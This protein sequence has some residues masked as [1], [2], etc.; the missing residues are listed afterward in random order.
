MAVP[1]CSHEAPVALAVLWPRPLLLLW[2]QLEEA[3]Q[4]Q[5]WKEVSRAWR[6]QGGRWSALVG[7]LGLFTVSLRVQGMRG[8]VLPLLVSC[9]TYGVSSRLSWLCQLCC[10]F[11]FIPTPAQRLGPPQPRMMAPQA[12][13]AWVVASRA[14]E[15]AGSL[16]PS[17]WGPV[18]GCWT[19]GLWRP[20]G[21][22]AGAPCL[23]RGGG[24]EVSK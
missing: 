3:R 4:G 14:E 1:L 21:C 13:R 5:R 6:R 12:R 9:T 19:C 10:V 17:G 22:L 15:G 23:P 24:G 20:W 7:G 11:L 8:H 2:A 18:R 16:G